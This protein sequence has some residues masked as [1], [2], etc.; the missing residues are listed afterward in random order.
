MIYDNYLEMIKRLPTRERQSMEK[1]KRNEINEL[2]TNQEYA[3]AEFSDH[4]MS[5]K[6]N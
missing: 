2:M 3:H 4:Y 1:K 5:W 6:A